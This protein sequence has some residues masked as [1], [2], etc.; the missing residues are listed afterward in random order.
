MGP[1]LLI[2]FM[3]VFGG[4]IS[5]QGLT[6]MV[7]DVLYDET[8]DILVEPTTIN[9][10]VL[11]A[12]GETA[13]ET[14]SI[15]N[16]GTGTLI[17]DNIELNISSHVFS[18][19][20][21]S[22]ESN[23]EPYESVTFTVTYDPE[24]YET[25][26]NTIYVFSN[27]PN[28]SSVPVRL[29]GFGDAPVI[30]IEPENF[31]FDTT[32]VGCE[33]MAEIVISN[34]GNVDLIIDQIDYFIS[35]PPDLG[36][37]DYESIYGVLPW[38]ITPG[39]DVILEIFYYPTDIDIDYGAI[40]V[41]SNDP[42]N[43][44]VTAEQI[45]EGFYGSP[46]EETF[47]QAIVNSVDILFVID[48]S[49][50]MGSNQTQLANNF[51]TFM[52]VFQLSGIDYHIGFITTDSYDLQGT[53]ITTSTV[54]PVTEIVQIIDD[55]GVAGNY[56]EKGIDFSYY[57]L[58]AGY[59]FG[60]GSIFWRNDSKLI[61]IYISDED[62]QSTSITPAILKAYV[63]S[64]KGVADYVA[65][66]AVAGDYPGGCTANG[67]ALEAYQYY[68]IV[69]Y[70]NGTFLSI[71]LNDWGTPLEI[72]ANESIL[73]SS[74]T[75]AETAVEETIYVEVD[76]VKSVDWTYDPTTNAV[77]FNPGYIPHA[78]S[79]IYIRYNAASDCLS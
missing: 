55:I 63:I 78:G 5:D 77:S 64:A 15:S 24:T 74:F 4:C 6:P 68:T 67:G 54:D 11:N 32:L 71:C 9:F 33:N 40:E 29:S 44:I 69:N 35:Y 27:D 66:H 7:D 21:L 58:Q 28:E 73:K 8:P 60:P 16:V 65:A 59:D 47:K 17:L 20:A 72:L 61:I 56:I 26:T 42:L 51:D 22:N 79:T 49:G 31:D 34:I 14:I 43:P 2:L 39:G 41:Y 46:F 1:L 37:E 70:L 36:I 38:T 30:N 18:I 48:N 76:N 57:A 19:S 25:D 52:D 3:F 62:D 13:S 23:I 75:L 53:L 10:G 45:A 12:D 50:S